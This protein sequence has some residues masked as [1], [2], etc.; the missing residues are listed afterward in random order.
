M[1]P[2]SLFDASSRHPYETLTPDRV[3]D[4]L[5]SI[6]LVGDGRLMALSSYENRVYQAHLQDP[7]DGVP[8]IVVAKFYRPGRWSEAQIVEEHAFGTQ[9]AEAE[10]PAV[11]PLVI[12]GTTLHRFEEF[13]FS[14]CPRRGG[15]SPELDDFE[16]LEWI[17]RFLARIHTVGAA[18]PFVERPAL[19]LASFGTASR[20]WLLSNQMVPLDV[21]A[22]WDKTCARALEVVA[23][24]PLASSARMFRWTLDSDGAPLG[25]M[26]TRR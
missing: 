9:L 7:P 19:D 14:V 15:R 24:S 2:D 20:E 11:C 21:Q 17:G 3:L 8:D 12:R 23:A 22:D 6:G 25:S 13:F 16:V 10:I 26:S 1:H 18:Q 5:D 4:A